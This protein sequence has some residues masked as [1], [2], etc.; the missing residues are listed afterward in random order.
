VEAAVREAVEAS[1]DFVSI[2]KG[3][4]VVLKPN[5]YCP[6]PAPTTTDPR[7]IAA[8]IR[9][10]RD[11]GARK[12][13]VAEGRS[14]STALFRKHARTTRACFEAVGM[15]RA[16]LDNGAEIAYLEDDEFI[17]VSDADA[18]VLKKAHVPRTVYEADT[19][20]DVPVLKIH[21][22]TLATL[23]IKNLHGVISDEDKLFAHDYSRL[24]Q[25]LVDIL[26]YCNPELTV[27][28]AVR[29]QEGDHASIGTPV[30]TGL[31]ISGRSHRSPHRA[32]RVD[33]GRLRRSV[34]Q[35]AV[36][37][38]QCGK[39][40]QPRRQL[41]DSCGQQDLRRGVGQAVLG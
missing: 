16:A 5:V 36:C 22:L 15:D 37:R 3:K 19:L 35:D 2:C 12:V 4:S 24:P 9:L 29:G 13:T 11:A 8:L 14:I 21:S 39:G 26:R 17:E 34:Q 25:K 10:A 27:I 41:E 7:V 30:E 18:V 28:D 23:G 6:S 40:G 31:I 20:I 32:A 38:I 33:G 1:C